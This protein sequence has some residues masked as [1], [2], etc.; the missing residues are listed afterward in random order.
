MNVVARNP[1]HLDL[2]AVDSDGRTMNTWWEAST[3]WADWF[4][5]SGG[6][7]S[8]GSPVTAIALKP[9]HLVLFTVGTDN[10]VCTTWWD[11]GARLEAVA[12]HPQTGGSTRLHG[13][14]G[15]P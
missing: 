8:P 5:V 14:R 13:E 15:R 10:L 12:A 11:G 7:A 4:Q 6:V 2:F 1:D 3:G 9:R